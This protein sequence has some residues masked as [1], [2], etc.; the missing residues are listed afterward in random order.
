[1]AYQPGNV[2]L[3]PFPFTDLST[4][5]VRPAVVVSSLGYQATEPDL[6]L[7]AITSQVAIATGPYD[8]VLADWQAAGL[9]FPSAF[10]PSSPRLIPRASSIRSAHWSPP[11]GLRSSGGCV[12]CSTSE[13]FAQSPAAPQG[14]PW[15]D[16]HAYQ[17]SRRA[18]VSR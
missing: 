8:Y 6:I 7:G 12:K 1:M 17:D 13:P 4:A 2:V 10:K 11:T 5:K 14:R 9:R 18:T 15:L 16:E 3:V